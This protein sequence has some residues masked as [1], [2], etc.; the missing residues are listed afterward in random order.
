[1]GNGARRVGN[2]GQRT[3]PPCVQ[4]VGN[5]LRAPNTSVTIVPATSAPT[6]AQAVAS[7][8]VVYDPFVGS[9][10]SIVAAEQMPEAVP[11]ARRQGADAA[12]GAVP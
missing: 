11:L 3:R 6:I 12:P 9:G 5:N 1:M 2:S 7:T 10:T 4:R 8:D